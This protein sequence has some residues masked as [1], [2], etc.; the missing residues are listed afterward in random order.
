MKISTLVFLLALT[1]GLCLAAEYV[2]R[3]EALAEHQ[4]PETTY[5]SRNQML[6]YLRSYGY[7]GALD[8]EI[9]DGGN[10]AWGLYEEE[11]D[12]QQFNQYHIDNM[13]QAGDMPE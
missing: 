8:G 5:P 11:L 7:S 3:E 9:G 6:E 13:E 1:W 10:E 2:D 12:K 4:C